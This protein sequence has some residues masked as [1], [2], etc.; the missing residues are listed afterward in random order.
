[1][2]LGAQ[3]YS[4]RKQMQTPEEIQAGF[5]RLKTMGYENVQVSGIGAIAPDE[6]HRIS[7]ETGLPIVVTHNPWPRLI[8]DVD[9]IIAD[10]RV[11]GCTEIGLGAMPKEY[12]TSAEGF[13]EFLS[14]ITVS[15]A[16][17]AESGMHFAYHNHAFEFAG[18]TKDGQNFLDALIDRCPDWH[19]ILD[20]YW[21]AFAGAKPEE[22]IRRLGG[23]K[24]PNIHFKDMARTELREICACGK[25]CLDF[26]MLATEC[27]KT[28]VKNVLV[29]QDNATDATDAFGEMEFSFNHLSPKI[30]KI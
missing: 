16:K 17:I 25:G 24:V 3:L 30:K 6:L 21:I 27:A 11:F 14:K 4:I 13:E 19:F 12:R 9:G 7:E 26:E 2:K 29:E 28:G 23:D 20:T 22:Y 10:H 5:V 15:A 18:V 1:M 8:D